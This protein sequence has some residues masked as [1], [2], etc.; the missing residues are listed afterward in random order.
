MSART[1]SASSGTPSRGATT[2]CRR[3]QE[4]SLAPTR[5]TFSTGAPRAGASSVNG[6]SAVGQTGPAG[7]AGGG[8]WVGL[9]VL[10]GGATRQQEQPER[11]PHRRTSIAAADLSSSINRTRSLAR[12][13][14]RS[15]SAGG[16]A[17]R[18]ALRLSHLISRIFRRSSP[19]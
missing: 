8:V 9:A 18:L 14:P 11:G 12:K 1:A 7:A 17:A 10:R 19:R 2:S 5:Q 3:N 16:W 13:T 4:S 15:A 6:T